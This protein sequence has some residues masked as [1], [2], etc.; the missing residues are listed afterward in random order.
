MDNGY[1]ALRIWYVYKARNG[2]G[3]D[4]S[5]VAVTTGPWGFGSDQRFAAATAY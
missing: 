2:G 4:A 1:S 5:T 3:V